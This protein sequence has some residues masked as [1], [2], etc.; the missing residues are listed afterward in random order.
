MYEIKYDF[1]WNEEEINKI[2]NL[3]EEIKKIILSKN[4]NESY[5]YSKTHYNNY[6]LLLYPAA[7]KNYY[8]EN[9]SVQ[10]KNING[11][12]IGLVIDRWHA[13]KHNG[14]GGL[15]GEPCLVAAIYK[16]NG[17]EKELIWSLNVRSGTMYYHAEFTDYKIPLDILQ[18]E[19]NKTLAKK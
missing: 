16:V 12:T 18:T 1:S 13:H 5:F 17:E 6:E 4:S 10:F 19:K 2:T 8:I 7:G 3:Y 14:L 15:N 9:G 11:E